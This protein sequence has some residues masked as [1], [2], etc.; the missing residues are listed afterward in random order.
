MIEPVP[1]L[2]RAIATTAA[3]TEKQSLVVPQPSRRTST[4]GAP[5]TTVAII[6]DRLR[7]RATST[8]P[9]GLGE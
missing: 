6:T 3:G 8:A 7:R 1:S 5:E 9:D 4:A 2:S